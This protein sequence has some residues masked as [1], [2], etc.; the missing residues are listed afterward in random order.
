M[1][2]AELEELASRLLPI[3]MDKLMVEKP[4]RRNLFLPSMDVYR[5]SPDAPFMRFSSCSS[6]DFFHPEFKRISDSIGLPQLWHRK[7][8]EWVFIVHHLRRCGVVGPDRRGLVFGVGQEAL[9]AL[10]AEEGARI[11]ATDAPPEI[12]TAAGWDSAEQYG[13]ALAAMPS[14]ALSRE[15]FETRV[16]WRVCDMNAIDPALTDYDFCWSSCCLEHLGSLRHG[17]DFIIHSVENTL[18]VGGVAVHTTEFN[19]SSN[20][21][22]IETGAAVL[23]RLRD[24]Q[25]LIGELTE[26]G[27][28]VDPFVVA[29][30]SLVI[31]GYVDTPPRFEARPHLKLELDGYTTTSAGLVIR[32]GR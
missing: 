9:P 24:L 20:T 12:A 6:R 4:W 7:Y 3:L 10:F 30:D 27:H 15:E 18:K 22:T 29:P 2:D 25:Q 31:D 13:A 23:Y 21:D 5:V 14:G 8:W 28:T 1:S 26:R 17:M 19:L 11:T 32:R 16:E